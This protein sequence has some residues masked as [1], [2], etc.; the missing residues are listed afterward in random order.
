MDRTDL[1]EFAVREICVDFT[2][3]YSSRWDVG[4]LKIVYGKMLRLTRV[5]RMEHL[6][7]EDTGIISHG[8]IMGA[9]CF[10][11]EGNKRASEPSVLYRQKS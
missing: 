4:H 8:V 10:W 3:A 9:V 1:D 2:E 5:V 7:R 6:W 11:E